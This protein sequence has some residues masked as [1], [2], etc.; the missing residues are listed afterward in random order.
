MCVSEFLFAQSASNID[1]KI[2]L[3]NEQS[4]YGLI[5]GLGW[6]GGFRYGN[7]IST[8]EKGCTSLAFTMTS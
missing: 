3:R 4:F 8:W 6:G 7:N 1:G 5:H 2:L